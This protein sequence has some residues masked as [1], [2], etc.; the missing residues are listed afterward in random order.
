MQRRLPWLLALPLMAAGSLAAHSIGYLALASHSAET[1]SEA[2]EAASGGT[3]SYLVSAIGLLAAL[4]L[5]ALVVRLVRP[6]R[7]RGGRLSPWWFATLPPLA[8]AFQELAERI[9]R[10]ESFPFHAALEPRF[11]LGLALQLPFAALAVAVARALL[12]V[13]ERYARALLDARVPDVVPPGSWAP[14]TR[15]PARIPCLA[16]GYAQR[17]PPAF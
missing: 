7:D 2:S 17:G 8:F 5:L 11:L 14:H 15:E 1:G 6:G 9:L 3:A 12:R 4:A 13:I 10:A 16:L